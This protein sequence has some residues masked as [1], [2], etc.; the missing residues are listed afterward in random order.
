MSTDR[1]AATRAFYD[2][3]AEE[4]ASLLPDLRYERPLEQAMLTEFVD[5]LP[6][7]DA[8]VLDAGCGTGRML[9]HLSAQGVTPLR[10]LDLSPEMVA[11]AR[12]SHPDLPVEVADLAA[13]P[14]DPQTARGVLCWYAIIHST[15]DEVGAILDEFGRVLRPG[16][17]LLLGFQAGA[18]ERVVDGRAYGHP[19]TLHGVLHEPTEIARML[20]QRGFTV[21]VTA[22]RAAHGEERHAQG[23]VLARR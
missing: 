11:H 7:D 1:H 21:I 22:H 19:L 2:T 23:F 15:R 3:V 17:A 20:A 16:G 13:L 14:L 9:T 5:A 8:P 6:D 10:G 18:G 4:Y 12:A